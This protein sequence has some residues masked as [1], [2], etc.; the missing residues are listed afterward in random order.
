MEE[1]KIQLLGLEHLQA[2]GGLTEDGGQLI[3]G[4]RTPVGGGEGLPL[5][6]GTAQGEQGGVQVLAVQLLEYG[7]VEAEL[8]LQDQV[9]QEGGQGQAADEVGE[10]LVF[11][12]GQGLN[13]I[14]EV[15]LIAQNQ[16]EGGGS[17]AQSGLDEAHVL[18]DPVRI[19]LQLILGGLVEES[20]VD[21]LVIMEEGVDVRQQDL[22]IEAVLAQDGSQGEGAHDQG[23]IAL[24]EP[25]ERAWGYGDLGM[26]GGEHVLGHAILEAFHDLVLLDTEAAN[27]VGG[28]SFERVDLEGSAEGDLVE[29][30]VAE[31]VGR[32]LAELAVDIQ[33]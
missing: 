4:D 9:D 1:G 19:G 26:E 16:G 5:L 8:L 11:Q 21:L 33:G 3:N 32:R 24:Q 2:A 17:L 7:A 15:E 29:V 23:G 31:T 14:V 12:S 18:K 10:A 30:A 22:V 13:R 20:G 25:A 28:K 6:G 27:L